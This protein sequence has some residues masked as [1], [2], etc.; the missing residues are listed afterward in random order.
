M[1]TYDVAF[2][3]GSKLNIDAYLLMQSNSGI[4]SLNYVY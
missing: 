1:D 3:K 4:L 2:N